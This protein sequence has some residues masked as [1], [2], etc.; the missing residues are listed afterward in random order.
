MPDSI[1]YPAVYGFP[2]YLFASCHLLLFKESRKNPP[3]IPLCKRGKEGD[4]L[5]S[6]WTKN[7]VLFYT[8][9]D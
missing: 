6:G 7:P 2:P 4:F 1:R 8:S 9:R 5:F 3:V